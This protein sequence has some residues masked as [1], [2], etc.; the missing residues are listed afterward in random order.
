VDEFSAANK[1]ARLA[2]TDHQ[3]SAI[4]LTRSLKSRRLRRDGE[5]GASAAMLAFV[6]GSA[7]I[8]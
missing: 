7:R 4:G 6:C 1:A 5:S 2:A 8:G 3:S